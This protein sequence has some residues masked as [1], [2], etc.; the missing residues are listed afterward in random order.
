MDIQDIIEITNNIINKSVLND[1]VSIKDVP[2]FNAI[3][4]TPTRKNKTEKFKKEEIK[5]YTNNIDISTYFFT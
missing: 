3:V 5:V 1:C 2:Y 4:E